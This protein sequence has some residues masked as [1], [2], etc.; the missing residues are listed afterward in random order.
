MDKQ[1]ARRN[2]LNKRK[3]MDSIN[4]SKVCF[5]ALIISNILAKYK[6]IGLYYPI[7][8]EINLMPLVD[9]YPDKE[10]YLPSTGSSLSFRRYNG[11]LV[12]GPFRTME[13]TGSVIDRDKIECFI[14]P[15]V[16]ISTDNR[17]IGYGKG[18]YD[19][20]LDGYSGL[21]IGVCYKNFSM[22]DIKM[23]E[24]DIRLDIIITG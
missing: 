7:G 6:R 10:F 9:Y 23:D 19:R 11:K 13:A 1:E 3:N 14:I 2:I 24:S 8:S 17:R 21:K 18:Y 16:G 12:P 15:C 22:L 4:A 5:D 20:Y